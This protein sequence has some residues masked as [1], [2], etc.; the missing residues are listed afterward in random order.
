MSS[1]QARSRSIKLLLDEAK[2]W[3]LL[4]ILDSV[5]NLLGFHSLILFYFFRVPSLPYL[6]GRRVHLERCWYDR[7]FGTHGFMC[8]RV[9]HYPHFL[10]NLCNFHTPK[11]IPNCQGFTDASGLVL[12]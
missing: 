10:R 9:C 2:S 4:L 11:Y 6:K 7:V 8:I 5:E 3:D 1:W 12:K